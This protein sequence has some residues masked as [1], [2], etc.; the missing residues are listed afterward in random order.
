MLTTSIVNEEEEA[1]AEAVPTF[2]EAG[3]E[4]SISQMLDS[5]EPA[6]EKEF[7]DYELGLLDLKFGE[8]VEV[9]ESY[10]PDWEITDYA[11]AKEE[12]TKDQEVNKI[13]EVVSGDT[14]SGIAEKTG[15]SMDKIIEL[16]ENIENENSTIRVE[17]ELIVT[18]PEPEL[19]VE[20]QEEE[21][22]EEDYD[23]EIQYVDN[24][25]TGYETTLT[26]AADEEGNTHYEYVQKASTPTEGI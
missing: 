10:L 7:S 22:Y 16:N 8:S 2:A 1:K 12:V 17:D 23:A 25:V 14:L 24:D 13:Y 4:E 15:I 21:Y 11:T 3:V 26:C 19:S 5:V 18:A 20:R 6:V 9:V